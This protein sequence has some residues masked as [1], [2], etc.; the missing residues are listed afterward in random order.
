MEDSNLKI[1][2][3]WQDLKLAWS[4]HSFFLPFL[5]PAGFLLLL[6]L[7][8]ANLLFA[9]TVLGQR[10][11]D[12]LSS[13]WRAANHAADGPMRI[14]GLTLAT[15]SPFVLALGMALLLLLAAGLGI[16]TEQLRIGLSQRFRW[17]LQ[18]DLL[19]ALTLQTGELRA[20]RQTGERIKTF[21]TD[22]AGGSAL[23]IFGILGLFEN[24]LKS[25][26]YAL[27]LCAI[28]DGWK[29]LWIIVPLTVVFQTLVNRSFSG[30]E[31]RAN[32]RGDWW[33]RKASARIV[34]F[35]E[36][37]GR[38][39][40]FGGE[41]KESAE[42]LQLAAPAGRTNRRYSY[43][44]SPGAAVAGIVTSL[45]LPLIVMILVQGVVP[46]TP[47][48]IVQAQSLLGLLLM[49]IFQPGYGATDDCR[50]ESGHAADSGDSRHY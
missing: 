15:E 3:F 22:S 16:G 36:L 30:V 32:E 47:G 14:L 31:R 19:D 37:V 7:A 4:F 28:P 25:L 10:I 29:V 12:T 5:L 21:M 23:L 49:S 8:Q 33:S 11:I 50:V 1:T 13:H 42:I 2:N 18:R 17:R 45:S 41:Q 43:I 24:G 34:R 39:V 44:S 38:L 40:Y 35:F 9:S 48:T 20:Q 6:T 27:G 26:T 46:V